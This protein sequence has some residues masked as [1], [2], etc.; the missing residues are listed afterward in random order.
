MVDHVPD[1]LLCITVIRVKQEIQLN[2]QRKREFLLFR[3]TEAPFFLETPRIL[4]S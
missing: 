2:M 3:V 4:F 1:L